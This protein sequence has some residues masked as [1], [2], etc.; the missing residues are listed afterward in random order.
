[1][2][3]AE[4]TAIQKLL[5]SGRRTARRGKVWT[6]IH[7][8][9]GAGEVMGS[10]YAFTA[11]ELQRLR[12]YAEHLTGLDPQFESTAGGRMAMAEKT[13]SEKLASDSVFGGLLLM[14]TAGKACIPVSGQGAKTPAGSALCVTP[15]SLD[16]KLLAQSMVVIVENGALLAHHHEIQLPKAWADCILLYRGHGDNVAEVTRIIGGH[17]SDRLALYYDFDPE[18]LNMALH[19]RKGEIL[20]PENWQELVKEDDAFREANQRSVYRKQEPLIKHL[21]AAA[22]NTPWAQVVAAMKTNEIAVMQEHIT[23]KQWALAAYP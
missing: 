16:R 21:E 14:A 13:N 6:R 10:E 9:T 19:H 5:T 4:F 18:G 17:P 23:A 3:S 1:M 7:E 12:K 2:S 15:E 20:I 11:G 22:E 8:E